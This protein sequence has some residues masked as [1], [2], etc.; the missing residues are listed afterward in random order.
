MPLLKTPTLGGEQLIKNYL[1]ILLIDLMRELTET[2][3]K[4]SLFL[5]KK[6]FDSKPV[7]EVMKILT[8][9]VEKS[10]SADNIASAV[11][12]SKAYIFKEFKKSTG[13]TVMCYY[14]ELKIERAKRLLREGEMTI[15]EI[16][17]K[18]SFDSANY[19]S[20]VFKKSTGLTPSAYKKREFTSIKPKL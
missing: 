19:F 8:E 17:E 9:G 12:Y 4:N 10:L 11:G 3:G 14:C 1:E 2:D 16:A 20:K 7:S 18:L 15:K 6:D 5:K 13:K